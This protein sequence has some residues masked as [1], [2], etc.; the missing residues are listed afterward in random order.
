MTIPNF[1]CKDCTDRYP[2]C[3]D[4]CEKY[5]E[6]KAAHDKRRYEERLQRE[7][8]MY[9]YSHVGDVLDCVAKRRRDKAGYSRFG[10]RTG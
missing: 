4:H 7:A 10:K 1:R 5:K 8:S 9:I 3:H 6:D 2:G